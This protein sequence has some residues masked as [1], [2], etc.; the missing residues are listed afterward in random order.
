M[1]M[2]KKSVNIILHFQSGRA[3]ELILGVAQAENE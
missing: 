3:I 2:C 1:Y